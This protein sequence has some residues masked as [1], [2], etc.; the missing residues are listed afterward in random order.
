MQKD[1]KGTFWGDGNILYLAKV[2]DFIGMYAFVKAYC[3]LNYA[4]KICVFY[5]MYIIPHKKF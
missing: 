3:L 1:H 2:V 4:L 5:C